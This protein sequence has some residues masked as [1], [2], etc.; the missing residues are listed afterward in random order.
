M[1]SF[2]VILDLL[3]FSFYKRSVLTAKKDKVPQKIENFLKNLYEKSIVIQG[4]AIKI[5]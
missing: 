1:E 4:R 5:K 2:Q 3:S